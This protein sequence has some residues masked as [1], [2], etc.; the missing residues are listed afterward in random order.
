MG[1]INIMSSC[2][3]VD[4]LA[5][6]RKSSIDSIDN[7]KVF[8]DFKKYMHVHR[9]IEDDIKIRLRK[10]NASGK[11]TLFL[12]CGSAG[13]G[14][15][16][17]LSY[18]LNYDQENLLKNFRVHNDATESNG[19]QKTAIE[20][21]NEVLD[22]FSDEN[23]NL[24]GQNMI[25]AINLG[26]LNNF[27]DSEFS[28]RYSKLREYV[29]N[30]NILSN[31]TNENSYN[32]QSPFQ[33]ITFADYQM[34]TL[35]E[36]GVRS[37]YIETLLAKVFGDE[38]E[39]PFNQAFQSCLNCPMQNKCPVRCN[40]IFLKNENVRK[41][42]ADLLVM[43]I[44]KEKDILTTRE[45]LNYFYDITVP[46]S[47]D[48]SKMSDTLTESENTI[49]NFIDGIVPIL[50]FDQ[51]GVTT[52]M[53]HSKL[54]DPVLIRDEKS[55]DLAI[56]FYVSAKCNDFLEDAFRNTPYVD[57]IISEQCLSMIN[58]NEEF[59]E[60]IFKCMIRTKVMMEIRINDSVYD[61]FINTLYLYNA[62]KKNKLRDLYESVKQAIGQWCGEDELSNLCLNSESDNSLLFENVEYKADL[63]CVPKKKNEEE[64]QRF[65]QEIVVGFKGKNDTRVSLE[66]D[67]SLF[68]MIDQLNH[69]Y[70]HTENDQNNHAEFISFIEKIIRLGDEDQEVFIISKQGVHSVLRKTEFGYEYEV[71][72]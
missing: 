59:K 43:T 23:L 15:S 50:L 2:A 46:Q 63:S 68:K 72:R 22:D 24:P 4:Q 38:R 35:S 29:L 13:D 37:K 58:K 45:I 28:K 6:L 34:Y 62:G 12:L 10:I 40:F 17:M 16:H 20:T 31:Y 27:I 42:I 57:Q 52:L 41:F 60:K 14:K 21:L 64:L 26:V 70:I 56:E 51:N 67:F 8:N 7:E 3:L 36:H 69:G 39:N 30:Q 32:N 54:N 11:K 66:I 33:H 65:R 61:R 19:P 53:E 9:N 47:F 1:N 71:A 55:D 18:L 25:L 44:I 48:F 5:H 49:E